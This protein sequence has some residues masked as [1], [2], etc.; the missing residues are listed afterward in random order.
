MDPKAGAGKAAGC[1]AVGFR[2]MSETVLV[3]H[4]QENRVVV[5]GLLHQHRLGQAVVEVVRHR[6]SRQGVSMHI[7]F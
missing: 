1:V 4:R 3:P 7:N 5:C 6:R 2:K